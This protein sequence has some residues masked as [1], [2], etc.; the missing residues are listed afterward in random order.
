MEMGNFHLDPKIYSL[1]EPDG[2][3]AE[4]ARC[5]DRVHEL[6]KV[7]RCKGVGKAAAIALDEE[8]TDKYGNDEEELFHKGLGRAKTN[9]EKKHVAKA[10]AEWADGDSIT[11]HYGFGMN[12]FCSEDFGK[13]YQKPSVL[14]EEHRK[15]LESDFGIK[16]V[17][18]FELARMLTE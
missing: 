14:D 2:G 10:I 12:L 15:W 8:L 9:S 7:L 18:L 4:L 6:A 13:S 16:F 5:M 11:S 17:T 1:Y 3:I